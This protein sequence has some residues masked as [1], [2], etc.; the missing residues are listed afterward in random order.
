MEK[1]VFTSMYGNLLI[2][3]QVIE[4]IIPFFQQYSLQSVTKRRNF[5]IF[6]QIAKLVQ[7]SKH[8]TESG[9]KQIR[10]LKSKMNLRTIGLA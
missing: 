5:L 9:V 3:K 6:C 10:I 4:K 8:L 2:I 1:G 7:S